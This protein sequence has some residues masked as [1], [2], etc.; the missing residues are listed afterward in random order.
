MLFLFPQHPKQTGRRV[1]LF[2]SGRQNSVLRTKT[3][4]QRLDRWL[5]VVTRT[6]GLGL[7]SQQ[8]YNNKHLDNT[9][10]LLELLT[11]K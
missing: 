1:S 9:T 4:L 10:I 7:C 8:M 6:G 5:R 3:H 11:P 2:S